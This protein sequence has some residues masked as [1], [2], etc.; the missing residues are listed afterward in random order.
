M[1][2]IYPLPLFLILFSLL[3]YSCTPEETPPSE[4][5]PPFIE[6][7]F[8]D[9]VLQ[10][11]HNHQD[12]RWQDSLVPYLT[13]ENPIYRKEAAVALGNIQEIAMVPFL[14]DMLTDADPEVAAAAAYAIGQTKHE[15]GAL[16][17]RT[18]LETPDSAWNQ[19]NGFFYSRL[20]EALGRCGKKLDLDYLIYKHQELTVPHDDAALHMAI[21]RFSMRRITT[22]ESQAISAAGLLDPDPAIAEQAAFGLTRLRSES[23]DT[24]I[25]RQQVLPHLDKLLPQVKWSAVRCLRHLPTEE[26]NPVLTGIFLD[27]TED[28]RCRVNALTSWTPEYDANMISRMKSVL[29]HENAQIAV[30]AVGVLRAKIDSAD[31]DDIL[32]VAAE[33]N[34]LRVKADL[35]RW[36]LKVA[37]AIYDANDSQYNLIRTADVRKII[38]EEINGTQDRYYHRNLLVALSESGNELDYLRDVTLKGEHPIYQSGGM[39]AIGY[40]LQRDS[41]R[42]SA[43]EE[44]A[45]LKKVLKVDDEAVRATAGYWLDTSEKRYGDLIKDASFLREAMESL[46]L[47]TDA[48][49]YL[50]LQ[51]ALWKYDP[52]EPQVKY[53]IPYNHPI[54]WTTA[55]RISSDAKAVFKTSRGEFTMDFIVDIAP[56]SVVNF[57]ELIEMDYFDG[58]TFHRIAPNFVAQ[59]GCSRGDGWGGYPETIR[60]EWPDIRY[61][62]GSVGIASAGKDTE[63]SQLFITHCP[64]P[65]L[66]G[67]YSIFAEVSAGMDIVDR[68]EMGDVIEDVVL[69]GVKEADKGKSPE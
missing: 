52:K 18:A 41:T 65:H 38:H 4:E 32:G 40:M 63:S 27:E 16:A 8:S 23:A 61:K 6:N 58:K 64:T 66:D 59:G 53:Q 17:L 42:L 34:N 11:I 62:T 56:A 2:N 12:K 47:P 21:Y 39:E 3:C 28:Y 69:V 29:L 36:A 51:S 33:A 54:D 48:E 46:D 1:R 68:L 43:E 20:T 19:D 22:P 7:R 67:N 30:A 45:F 14:T 57:V 15:S 5:E 55:A 10:A 9:P 60:S 35:Y 24:S 37:E 44:L 13:H 31:I 25:I 49:T 26:V 50:I